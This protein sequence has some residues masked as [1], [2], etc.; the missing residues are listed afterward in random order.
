MYTIHIFLF[1]SKNGTTVQELK[2]EG[3]EDYILKEN[4]TIHLSDNG[5]RVSLQICKKAKVRMIKKFSNLT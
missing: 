1:K 5:K 2:L 3:V 4:D